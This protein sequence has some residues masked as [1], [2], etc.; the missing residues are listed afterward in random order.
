MAALHRPSHDRGHPLPGRWRAAGHASSR[1]GHRKPS[2]QTADAVKEIARIAK[3]AKSV[4]CRNAETAGETTERQNYCT[5]TRC[6]TNSDVQQILYARVFPETGYSTFFNSGD[7]WQS[8]QFWQFPLIATMQTPNHG[9]C[10]PH[11]HRRVPGPGRPQSAKRP[12]YA[13]AG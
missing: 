2:G 11:S 5:C 8:W 3:I 13:H 6:S 7:F 12:G 9:S 1:A 10:D 4:K